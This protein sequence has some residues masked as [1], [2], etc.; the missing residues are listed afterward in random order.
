VN[1]AANSHGCVSKAL[2]TRGMPSTPYVVSVVGSVSANPALNAD[3]PTAALRLL[4]GEAVD[5]GG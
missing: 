5:F 2:I 3:S 1:W 4:V